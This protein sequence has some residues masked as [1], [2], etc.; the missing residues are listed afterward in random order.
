MKL[1]ILSFLISFLSLAQDHFAV[2]NVRLF[3]GE[4]VMEKVNVE[5]RGG[6]VISVSNLSLSQDI[7]TIDGTGKTLIPA[8]SNAH[9]HLWTPEDLKES[10]RAGVLN[11]FDM[12][13]LEMY[14]DRLRIFKDSTSYANF[15][16]AGAAATAPEGHGT[17]YG[18][19]TPTLTT[20]S[21]ASNFIN[22]RVGNGADYIK[23]IVE[24]R[25]ATLSHEVV[26]K[27]I[28]E[29]HKINKIAVVHISLLADAIKVLENNAD[30]LVHIWSDKPINTKSLSKLKKEKSFFVI[31]TMLTTIKALEYMNKNEISTGD[32]MSRAL[33]LDELKRLYDAKI[34][35]LTGTDPPNLNINYGTDLYQ[36]MKLFGEAGIPNLE[37]LKCA[38]SNISKAFGIKDSGKIKSGFKADM[39]LIDG[40]PVENIADIANINT[41]WKNGKVLTQ[42]QP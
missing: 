30:G 27:L 38:T 35:L 28:E 16:A 39:I 31:P 5:V 29:S 1:V 41:I 14:Q 2:T 22:D 15:Y 32:S 42:K 10:A 40:N 26:A 7:Q 20:V 17:Q 21:E 11:V 12:H 23:I 37:V 36:E 18:F 9:V 34:P 13:G 8:L 33:L 24:P 4:G 6:F 19:P 3:D 25:K